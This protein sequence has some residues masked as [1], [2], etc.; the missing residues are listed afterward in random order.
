MKDF[1]FNNWFDI[2]CLVASV[3]FFS[4]TLFRTRN[5]SLSKNVSLLF[6]ELLTKLRSFNIDN[7][8]VVDNTDDNKVVTFDDYEKLLSKYNQLKEFL[9]NNLKDM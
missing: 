2:L 7:K 6:G 9:D 1:I 5:I 4:V 8:R 3:V